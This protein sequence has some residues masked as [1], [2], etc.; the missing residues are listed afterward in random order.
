M[1]LPAVT[2][3]LARVARHPAVDQMLESLRR[4]SK[5]ESLAG[6]TDPA[7]ALVAAV[8]ATEL[9]RPI[10]F[11]CDTERRAAETIEP[12]QFFSRALGG[13]TV[14]SLPGLDALPGQGVGPHPEILGTR[15]ATLW[16]LASGQASVVVAPVAA[17]LLSFASR[18]FYEQLSLTLERD[19]DVSL[20]DVLAHLR[21]AGY[22]RADLVEMPG[23]FAV[24][25]GILDIFPP[26]APRPARVELLGDT[27]ESVRAFDPET[28]RSTGPLSRITLPSLTEFP[29]DGGPEPARDAVGSEVASEDALKVPGNGRQSGSSTLFELRDEML[30]ILDEPAA[31]E[32]AATQW[33]ARL[34]ES[35]QGRGNS[36][37][38]EDS[39][40]VSEG[41]P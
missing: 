2:E 25:G 22:A 33:R 15:A 4:G 9:R 18:D 13:A 34:Q 27:V 16:R 39:D 20:E 31:I 6:L 7:K 10:L 19:Q 40:E 38:E 30:V 26:E 35:A 23:Q 5:S 17:T 8:V 21:R 41:T 37:T 12:L 32:R 3:L 29:L 36:A 24:R 11:L 1:L 28:Q 14:V